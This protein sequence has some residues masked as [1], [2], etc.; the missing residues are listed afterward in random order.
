[1]TSPALLTPN[2]PFAL[3]FLAYLQERFPPGPMLTVVVTTGAGVAL[4]AGAALGQAPVVLDLGTALAAA[5]Y[6]LIVLLLR[7]LDESKDHVRDAQAYPERLLSRGVITLPDL[8]RASLVVGILALAAAAPLGVRPLLAFALA[9]VY[10]LLME[11][12]FFLGALL[13]RD[14]FLYAAVHQPINPLL[15]VALYQAHAAAAPGQPG[16]LVPSFGLVVGA[17]LGL[18]FGFEVARKIWLPEEERPALVD[19]YSAHAVGPRGAALVALLALLAG[20]G[21]AGAFLH[22]EGLP[23]WALL[24]VG[25]GALLFLASAGRFA[26][27]PWAGASKQLQGAVGLGS[28]LVHGGLIAAVLAGPGASLAVWAR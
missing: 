17:L 3:R 4:T 6:G 21:C 20:A 22:L 11:R 7:L 9:V 24:P 19:S 13:R 26:L 2:H 28:L 10:A 23:R 12:E 15:T 8:R 18:G 5:A 1:M 16:W 25:L 14:V 27:R